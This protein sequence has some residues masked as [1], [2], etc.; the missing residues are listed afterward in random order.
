MLCVENIKN[1]YFFLFNGRKNGLH[2][3]VNKKGGKIVTTKENNYGRKS[4]RY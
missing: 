4:N 3:T 2:I 1:F